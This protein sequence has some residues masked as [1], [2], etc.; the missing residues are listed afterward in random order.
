MNILFVNHTGAAS[1]AEFALM[2]LVHAVRAEHR[3]AVACPAVGPLAE[4]VDA[5]EVERFSVPAFEASLRLH[6]VRTPVGIGRLCAATAALRRVTPRFGADLL[7]ANT[8]RAGLMCALASRLGGP[9]LVVRAHE[10]VPLTAVGRL[11][12][13]VLA[14]SASAIVAVSQDTARKFNEGLEHPLA[15]HVYNSF[16][17]ERFDCDR[18]ELDGLREELHIAPDAALLGQVAQITPWKG[19]DTSIRALEELR[20]GGLDAHLLIVGGIAFAG[21]G[22]R[23]D[24]HGY[25]RDLHQ[26]VNEL[27]VG[28]AVHFLGSRPDVPRILRALDLS[29]L[30]SWSEPFANVM[31]ES[32]AMGTPLL[33]SDVG[34][35]PELVEDGVSGRLLPPKRPDVW[36]AAARQLL[37]DRQ[38]LVHMGDRA[39]EATSRFR[40]E[41]HAS[42]M[43]AVY[44]RVLEQP[45]RAPLRRAP[46]PA[47]PI[48]LDVTPRRVRWAG[49]R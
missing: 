5:A 33:V 43:L 41:Q 18:V 15:T 25:L 9:P 22:V 8:P 47:R 34:G 17:R 12:R 45:E 21:K 28:E 14:H 35:G 10:H 7:H 11:T 6:P 38:A 1:G 48:D 31:L 2:R 13:F 42:D 49:R 19:Q 37:G 32:M 39:R 3:V 16:D 40:D 36:A 20:R 29:M 30:P 46:D 4:L 23:Y 24:N 26:L 27:G 44:R